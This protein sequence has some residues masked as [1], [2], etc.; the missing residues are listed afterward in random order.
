MEVSTPMI[1]KNHTGAYPERL[2]IRFPPGTLAAVDTLAKRKHTKKQD[3]FRQLVV[4]GL[5]AAGVNLDQYSE[6]AP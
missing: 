6:T 5:E 4:A 3:I 2:E 1:D